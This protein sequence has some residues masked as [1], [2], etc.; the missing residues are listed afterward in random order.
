M[1][2]RAG[3]DREF[4]KEAYG[5]GRFA[6]DRVKFDNEPLVVRR[7]TVAVLGTIQAER[8]ARL[9]SNACEDDGLAARFLLAWPAPV[10]LVKLPP[11]VVFP[12][13]RGA[14]RPRESSPRNGSKARQNRNGSRSIAKHRI[15]SMSSA[16]R[17]EP[18]EPGRIP[19]FS[20]ASWGNCRVR[21]LVCRAS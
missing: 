19:G 10:P 3:A 14:P 8:L 6:A 7:L 5:G 1:R 11:P 12:L 16:N 2:R 15:C 18:P 13:G 17:S 4:W 20:R 21:L 9:L